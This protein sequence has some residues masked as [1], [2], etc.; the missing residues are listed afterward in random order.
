MCRF[1]TKNTVSFLIFWRVFFLLNLDEFEIDDFARSFELNLCCT[2]AILRFSYFFFD[3]E[4]WKIN[5]FCY[6]VFLIIFEMHFGKCFLVVPAPKTIILFYFFEN[7]LNFELKTSSRFS[8]LFLARFIPKNCNSNMVK[9][10]RCF[11]LK[12]VYL[13]L[14]NCII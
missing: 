3:F 14:K 12:I 7:L 8:I 10:N 11:S 5:V 4:Q 1:W 9:T 13:G 2:V 6:F